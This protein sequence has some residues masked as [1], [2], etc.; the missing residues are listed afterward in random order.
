MPCLCLFRYVGNLPF[1]ASEDELRVVFAAKGSVEKVVIERNS[2]V[3]WHFECSQCDLFFVCFGGGQE[4]G[5]RA[6]ARLGTGQCPYGT[7]F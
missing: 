5:R 1:S 7:T 2:K 3:R 6:Y 4:E